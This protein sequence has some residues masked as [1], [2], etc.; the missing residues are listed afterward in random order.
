[1]RARITTSSLLCHLQSCDN[2]QAN[3]LV[4]VVIRARMSG[5]PLI[6]G[7]S[8]CSRTLHGFRETS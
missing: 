8:Y 5:P 1:M 7:K 6:A 3:T 2:V 4:L